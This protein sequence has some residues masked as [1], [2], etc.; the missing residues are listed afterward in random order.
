MPAGPVL[1]E[2]AKA[3]LYGILAHLIADIAAQ[4]IEEEG[5]GMPSRNPDIPAD[6]WKEVMAAYRK[7]CDCTDDPEAYEICRD[8]LIEG[9]ESVLPRRSARRK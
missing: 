3:I 4:R 7:V 9:L 8:R 1:T 2:A 6:A 5:P